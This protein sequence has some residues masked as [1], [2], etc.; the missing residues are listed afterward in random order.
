[1]DKQKRTI[2][3]TLTWKIVGF[4]VLSALTFFATYDMITAS[5][6][7]FSYHIV[8]LF[9]FY[10]HERIWNRIAWGKNKGLFV[11]MTGMSGA[12]KSTIALGVAKNL[13]A[14]GYAVEIIDGDEY[15][16]YLCSDLGFTE[17]DRK[18]NINRLGF[19]AN[20]L[21]ENGIIVI[22]AAINPYNEMRNFLKYFFE[23][24]I[25]YVEAPIEL[26]SI[27][28]V[29]GLYKRANLPEDHEDSVSDLEKFILKNL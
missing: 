3:K 24:K 25:V 9:S 22:M 1:M 19:V 16:K 12:G 8:Q 29:K 15:R 10:F 13:R 2:I 17:S 20:K 6:I 11:Q 27:R 5:I 18:E 23:A 26:L 4:S 7:T 21:A 28:D 14:K